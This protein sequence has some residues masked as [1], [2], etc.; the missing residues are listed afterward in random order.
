MIFGIPCSGWFKGTYFLPLT[1]SYAVDR[2]GKALGGYDLSL[3][4]QRGRGKPPV[5]FVWGVPFFDEVSLF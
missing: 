4:A 1:A 3:Y 2:S 5:G